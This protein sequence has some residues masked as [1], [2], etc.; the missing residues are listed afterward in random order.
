M[1][2]MSGNAD[3]ESMK[4]ICGSYFVAGREGPVTFLKGRHVHNLSLGLSILV[5]DYLAYQMHSS[6]STGAGEKRLTAWGSFRK[7][8]KHFMRG[9]NLIQVNLPSRLSRMGHG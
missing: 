1:Q 7:Q 6:F 9:L 3:Q 5:H 4:V 2:I 8:N